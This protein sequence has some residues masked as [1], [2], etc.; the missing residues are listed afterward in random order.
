VLHVILYIEIIKGE[1]E[2]S[3]TN[4]SH[5][6][7]ATVHV[8]ICRVFWNLSVLMLNCTYNAMSSHS[9]YY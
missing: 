8:N 1:L 9:W 3:T 7:E 2:V 4:R 6:Q 5:L